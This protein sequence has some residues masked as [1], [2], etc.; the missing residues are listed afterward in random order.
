MTLEPSRS[1]VRPILAARRA[2]SCE[3]QAVDSCSGRY[4]PPEFLGEMARR[5]A[6]PRVHTNV[7]EEPAW[8]QNRIIIALA[9]GQVNSLPFDGTD[10]A[11]NFGPHA[12]F[13]LESEG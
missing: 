5:G 10:C 7:V 9:L 3:P 1:V 11:P 8:L 2:D 4:H 12:Y 13:A 6:D